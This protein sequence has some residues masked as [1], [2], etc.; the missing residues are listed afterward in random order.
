MPE[1]SAP[2]RVTLAR[3][4]G[5]SLLSFSAR[6][7]SFL[8]AACRELEETRTAYRTAVRS[9]TTSPGV[10]A[11]CVPKKVACPTGLCAAK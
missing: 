1:S 7:R 6:W 11:A 2:A 10:F 3:R 8:P 9:L 5:E 4:S